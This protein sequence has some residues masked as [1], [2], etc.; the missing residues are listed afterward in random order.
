LLNCFPPLLF[1]RIRVVEIEDGFRA[2]RVRVARSLLTRNLHGTTFGGT[3][4]S[5]ADPYYAVMYWQVL[6]RMGYRVQAWLRRAEI[7]YRLPASTALT[8][9]FRLSD[10]EIARAAAALDEQGRY[11]QRHL[12]EALD[13]EGQV[14][15]TVQTEVYLRLPKASQRE[16]S[17]F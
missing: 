5:A 6:A 3:I 15:A 14:C 7:E 17:A 16:V 8:L 4:F 13:R 10:E 9:E 11:S 2:C 1:N 12:V